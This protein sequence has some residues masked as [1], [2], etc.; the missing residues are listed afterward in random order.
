MIRKHFWFCTG[1]GKFPRNRKGS[2]LKDS[3]YYFG[4]HDLTRKPYA[5]ISMR[6]RIDNCIYYFQKEEE[7]HV[8]P[9]LSRT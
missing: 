9:T 5:L 3:F 8:I 7:K 2:M 6:F 1:I 4:E